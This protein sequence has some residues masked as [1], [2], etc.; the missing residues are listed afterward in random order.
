M[1]SVNAY[2]QP[3]GGLKTYFGDVEPDPQLF[4]SPHSIHFP[5][6]DSDSINEKVFFLESL[7]N[8]IA[9]CFK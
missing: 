8:Y 3:E 6:P 9:K 7:D 1:E 5:L 4:A 2:Q